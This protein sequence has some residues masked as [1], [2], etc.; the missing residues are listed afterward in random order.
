MSS[1]AELKERCEYRACKC[2]GCEIFKTREA[3]S[4]GEAH[5]RRL[6]ACTAI[7]GVL[8]LG[9]TVPMF[10]GAST[11]DRDAQWRQLTAA[12][13]LLLEESVEQ[14]RARYKRAEVAA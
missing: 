11:R 13:A 1:A 8:S 9:E 5:D 14:V 2:S 10:V 4:R 6:A 12:L 3:T 7:S